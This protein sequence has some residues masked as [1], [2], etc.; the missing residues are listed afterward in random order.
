MDWKRILLQFMMVRRMDIDWEYFKNEVREQA[1]AYFEPL[2]HEDISKSDWQYLI[3]ILEKHIEKRNQTELS[4]PEYERSYTFE[5]DKCKWNKASKQ[6]DWSAYIYVKLDNYV[7]REGISFHSNGFIGFAGWAD[8]YNTRLFTDAFREWVDYV[9]SSPNYLVNHGKDKL[10]LVLKTIGES[11]DC[12]LK[13]KLE[14]IFE[15]S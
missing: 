13:R 3:A 2:K 11:E 9:K 5:L 15:M 6:R 14:E 1:R 10:S 8:N 12:A 4:K 7:V